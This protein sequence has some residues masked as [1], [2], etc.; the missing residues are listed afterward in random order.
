MAGR[1]GPGRWPDVAQDTAKQTAQEGPP[2]RARPSRGT[3]MGTPSIVAV[4][5]TIFGGLGR[6]KGLLSSPVW[7]RKWRNYTSTFLH[8]PP[9]SSVPNSPRNCSTRSKLIVIKLAIQ[10][11]IILERFLENRTGPFTKLHRNGSFG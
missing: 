11:R 7:I 9:L 3:C 8:L 5:T 4:M 2:A 6:R 10:L 1:R